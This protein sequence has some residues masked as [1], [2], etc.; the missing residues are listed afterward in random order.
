M[1]E[2]P[3]GSGILFPG[4]P[5]Q[6]MRPITF[7]QAEH[8]RNQLD[9]VAWAPIPTDCAMPCGGA[10]VAGEEADHHR[11]H[12]EHKAGNQ[13]PIQRPATRTALSV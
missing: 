8:E 13:A 4:Q 9:V 10:E 1:T 12:R 7:D 3:G 5:P 11:P 2:K 6:T